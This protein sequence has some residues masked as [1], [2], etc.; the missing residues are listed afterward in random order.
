MSQT[1]ATPT[2]PAN[3]P[4][5]FKPQHDSDGSLMFWGADL[6]SDDDLYAEAVKYPG[7]PDDTR[8]NLELTVTE[9]TTEDMRAALDRL[10]AWWA[11][12]E[13]H[14]DVAEVAR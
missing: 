11:A 2:S 4:P 1:T 5:R 6:V 13:A 9:G 14:L 3:V 8:Y 12:Q 10:C 7:T